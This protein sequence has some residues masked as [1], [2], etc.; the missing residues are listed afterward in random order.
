MIYRRV[1]IRV[2]AL[3]KWKVSFSLSSISEGRTKAWISQ[4]FRVCL[5]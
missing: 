3:R 2:D 5:L 1:D 4:Q